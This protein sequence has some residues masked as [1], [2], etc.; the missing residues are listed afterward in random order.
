MSVEQDHLLVKQPVSISPARTQLPGVRVVLTVPSIHTSGTPTPERME[1]NYVP[2]M[3]PPLPLA[4]LCMVP[5]SFTR[6]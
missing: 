5:T 1:T 2:N 4:G 3:S 6:I